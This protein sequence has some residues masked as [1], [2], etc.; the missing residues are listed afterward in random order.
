MKAAMHFAPIGSVFALI[1]WCVWSQWYPP[2]NC[3]LYQEEIPLPRIARSSTE[4]PIALFYQ[5]DAFTVTDAIADSAE[6]HDGSRNAFQDAAVALAQAQAAIDYSRDLE[7]LKLTATFVQGKRKRAIIGGTI[8]EPGQTLS[9]PLPDTSGVVIN[10][11]KQDLV[12][13]DYRGKRYELTYDGTR[14]Q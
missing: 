6:S 11:I 14:Q 2:K 7:A 5:R 3:L 4:P 13:L 10:D 9:A 8:V 12:L 1:V